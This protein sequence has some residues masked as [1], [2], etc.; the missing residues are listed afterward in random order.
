MAKYRHL[1]N[2]PIHEAVI[3]FRVKLPESFKLQQLE[4]LQKELASDYP[5]SKTITK[6]GWMFGVEQNVPMSK[7]VTEGISG[8]RLFSSDEKSVVQFRNDGFTFSRLKPYTEWETIFTEAKQ[9]WAKYVE[10]ASPEL[11]TRIAARYINRLELPP[12]IDFDDYLT[13]APIIPKSLPQLAS[14][15]LSRITIIDPTSDIKVHLTQALEESVEPRDHV[16]IILDIDAFKTDNYGCDDPRMW[17]KFNELRDMKNKVFFEMI[18]E[19]TA[20]LYK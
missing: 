14:N 4:P 8:Y 15:F 17:I 1:E 18:T 2:A 7:I 12:S 13:S 10:K 5:D 11:V 6:T 19:K 3:D 16:I 20:E 9:L